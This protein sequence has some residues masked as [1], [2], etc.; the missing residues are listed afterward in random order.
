MALIKNFLQQKGAKGMSSQKRGEV[1]VV[2]DCPGCRGR[3]A[4]RPFAGKKGEYVPC[5]CCDA[6][7]KVIIKYVPFAERR[8]IKD[9]KVVLL[10]PS[11][12]ISGREVPSISYQEFLE[13]KLPT[14]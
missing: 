11:L 13:G 9:A 1:E 4:H 3:G 14:Y 12:R 7:G 10:H 2:A 5:Q 8:E 6:T